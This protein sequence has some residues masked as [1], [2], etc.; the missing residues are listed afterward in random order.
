MSKRMAGSGSHVFSL[1][2]R[3]VII[4]SKEGKIHRSGGGVDVSCWIFYFQVQEKDRLPNVGAN[5]GTLFFIPV[6]A[7][8]SWIKLLYFHSE[9]HWSYDRK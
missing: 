5:L 8:C 9:H 6:P 7:R 2:Y 1:T 3:S 4:G